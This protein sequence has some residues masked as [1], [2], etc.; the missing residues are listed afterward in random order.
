M[1]CDLTPV[2]GECGLHELGLG[3]QLGLGKLGRQADELIRVQGLLDLRKLLRQCSVELMQLV[4]RLRLNG[5]L[6]HGHWL[7]LELRRRLQGR[8]RYVDWVWQRRLR[9]I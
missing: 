6:D 2:V 7:L 9:W 8:W 1:R 5:H 3:P 4:L